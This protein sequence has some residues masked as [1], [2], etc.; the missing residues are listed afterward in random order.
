MRSFAFAAFAAIA[1][2][3]F[4]NDAPID[5]A[6]AARDDCPKPTSMCSGPVVMSGA[7]TTLTYLCANKS[8]STTH[9]TVTQITTIT[10]TPG[11]GGPPPKDGPP[12]NDPTTTTTVLSTTTTYTT[13]TKTVKKASSLAS[14]SVTP[15][16]SGTSVVMPSLSTGL[17]L[18]SNGTSSG[19]ASPTLHGKGETPNPTYNGTQ[20]TGAAGQAGFI[21]RPGGV[22]GNISIAMRNS[23]NES[24]IPGALRRD[25]RALQRIMRSLQ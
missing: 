3:E 14:A 25:V 7:T 12:A 9:V 17:G 20:F 5:A 8:Q 19:Y 10:A 15:S 24:K 1:A 23:G 4:K 6:L 11:A 18:K 2:A 22:D 13:V 16:V 21:P